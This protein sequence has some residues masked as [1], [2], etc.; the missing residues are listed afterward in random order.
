MFHSPLPADVASAVL[1]Y[2]SESS[3]YTSDAASACLFVVLLGGT[4]QSGSV[5][6]TEVEKMLHELPFWAGDGRNHLLL[7]LTSS[8]VGSDLLRGVNIGRAMIA[9][10]YFIDTAFRPQFDVVIPPNLGPVSRDRVWHE[11]PLISPVRRKLLL[12]YLGEYSPIKLKDGGRS[13]RNL[14]EDNNHNSKFGLGGSSPERRKPLSVLDSSS[15]QS[16][17][18]HIEQAIVSSLKSFQV[19]YPGSADITLSCGQSDRVS[20]IPSEWTMCNP[21]EKRRKLILDST[22]SLIL[23]PLNTSLESTL[24][25]QTR[26]YE[27][28]KHGAIPVIVGSHGQMPFEELLRWES[29]TVVLPTPRITEIP[30]FLQSF[31]DEAVSELRLRGRHFFLTYMSCTHALLDSVLATLRLVIPSLLLSFSFHLPLTL[32]T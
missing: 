2:F 6:A 4:G 28:L 17:Y 27:T 21:E 18:S 10:P 3:Y 8:P 22:F 13:G 32:L 29:A 19:N 15:S 9:Q 5:S 1:S 23:L 30:F 12:S 26:L 24:A 11:L 16:Y 25:V 31:P 20:S 14:L 7:T